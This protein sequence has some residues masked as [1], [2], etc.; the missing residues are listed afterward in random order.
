MN[1]MWAGSHLCLSVC[2]KIIFL[3]VLCCWGSV[4]ENWRSLSIHLVV[5]QSQAEVQMREASLQLSVFVCPVL[6]GS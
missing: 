3:F 6:P 1:Y 5:G 4:V 2:P